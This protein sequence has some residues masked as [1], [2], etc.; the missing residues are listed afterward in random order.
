MSRIVHRIEGYRSAAAEVVPFLSDVSEVRYLGMM[1]PVVYEA[2]RPSA[3][4]L[5]M[6]SDALVLRMDLATM[7]IPPRPISFARQCWTQ[8]PPAAIVVRDDQAALWE[9]Y[10]RDAAAI[11]VKRVVFTDSQLDH[12][13]AWAVM[14]ARHHR[15]DVRRAMSGRG[16]A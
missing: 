10:A 13:K 2:M 16:T 7:A 12:A 1:T 3:V 5:T 11:G 9:L 14:A 6:A 15:A 8:T 4:P